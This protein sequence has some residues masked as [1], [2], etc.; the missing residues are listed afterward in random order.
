MTNPTGERHQRHFPD[1]DAPQPKFVQH[2]PEMTNAEATTPVLPPTNTIHVIITGPINIASAVTKGGGTSKIGGC[3][4]SVSD[5][6][7]RS[8]K[9]IWGA[10]ATLIMVICAIIGAVVQIV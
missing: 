2:P 1:H 10:I 4:D 8:K 6:T 5:H 9:K 7:P 3:E